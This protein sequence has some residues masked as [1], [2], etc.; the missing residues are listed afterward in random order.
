[1]NIIDRQVI[2][3]ATNRID[4]YPTG[5]KNVGFVD[6]MLFQRTDKIL[7]SHFKVK[8]LS[9]GM[10]YA[11]VQDMIPYSIGDSAK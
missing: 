6:K 9:G 7:A 4:K 8:S 2:K 11:Y 5:T 3:L 1:M 10:P